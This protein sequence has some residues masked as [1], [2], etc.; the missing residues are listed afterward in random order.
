MIGVAVGAPVGLVIS[1]MMDEGV[2]VVVGVAAGRGRPCE[3]PALV[4]AAA[5]RLPAPLASVSTPESLVAPGCSGTVVIA[6]PDVWPPGGSV[7]VVVV[8]TCSEVEVTTC[9]WSPVAPLAWVLSVAVLMMLGLALSVMSSMVS[10]ANSAGRSS[11]GAQVREPGSA[12]T[13]TL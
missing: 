9:P 11:V 13:L 3:G 1:G 7:G 2:V 10:R 8:L 5:V 4:S 12:S 6:A